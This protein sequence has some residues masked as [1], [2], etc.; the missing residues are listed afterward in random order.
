MISRLRSIPT[1]LLTTKTRPCLCRRSVIPLCTSR[2]YALTDGFV[3]GLHLQRD[4]C[5]NQQGDKSRDQYFLSEFHCITTTFT[6]VF[7]ALYPYAMISP[8]QLQNICLQHKVSPVFFKSPGMDDIVVSLDGTYPKEGLS[9]HL[10]EN[11]K[12]WSDLPD[13]PDPNHPWRP[14]IPRITTEAPE[15]FRWVNLRLFQYEAYR[16]V[17]HRAPFR[18]TQEAS[19]SIV[20]SV[21]KLS[22]AH[23]QIIQCFPW[24]SDRTFT[25]P[26]L[27]RADLL[28][29]KEDARSVEV[30]I[31]LAGLEVLDLVGFYVY[32]SYNHHEPLGPTPINDV[33]S[34]SRHD[35]RGVVL[36]LETTTSQDLVKFLEHHVPVY[37]VHRSDG[38][39]P[40]QLINAKDRDSELER[41]H[42]G[43]MS[44]HRTFKA[45]AYGE[46]QAAR[47]QSGPSGPAP[48]QP[49][50]KQYFLKYK[51]CFKP[52]G[53]KAF[54]RL[55]RNGKS[56][57]HKLPT[58]IV[59][60]MDLYEE[61]TDDEGFSDTDPT[62]RG[63]SSSGQLSHTRPPPLHSG[64]SYPPRRSR[65]PSR[66][67]RRSRSPLR[68]TGPPLRR[69]RSP[70]PDRRSGFPSSRPHAS[71]P[72]VWDDI[73]PVSRGRPI[74]QDVGLCYSY[75]SIRLTYRFH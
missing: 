49:G 66:A 55:F 25:L 28:Q 35:L 24:L 14:Y 26:P 62:T 54:D 75:P 12:V 59:D 11:M 20:R 18:L 45:R 56:S 5:R 42:R 44:A 36:D 3:H 48:V 67:Y 74:R 72:I 13:Y 60:I 70:S 32:C 50:K 22:T 68:R 52:V 43:A 7:D 10:P 65:S 29:T 73:S 34:W 41:A 17:T 23:E 57:T 39:F 4:Q 40:P 63:P 31:G 46:R 38:P 51:D 33:L 37:Y 64:P 47:H 1:L 16:M 61:P 8:S 2:L 9:T 58:G 69:S 30:T 6:H 15:D 21:A 53:K 19:P 71:G 27:P